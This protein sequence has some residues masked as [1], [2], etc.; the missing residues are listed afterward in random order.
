M[1]NK[2]AGVVNRVLLG[3]LMLGAGLVKLFV[4]GSDGV[5]GMLSG[6][7]FPAAPFFF[8]RQ[9]GA[10][11]PS[12]APGRSLQEMLHNASLRPGRIAVAPQ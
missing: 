6:M 5:A 8:P 1:Y 2:Y 10:E 11:A 4:F 3:L 9:T 12:I 7:G